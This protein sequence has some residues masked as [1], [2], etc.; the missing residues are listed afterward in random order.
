MSDKDVVS[1]KILEVNEIAFSMK[2]LSED[3]NEL[4]FGKNLQYGLGF[5]LNIEQKS[6]TFRIRTLVN[7][8]IN[9]IN[10]IMVS[11]EVEVVFHVKNLNKVVL[12]DEQTKKL[13]IQNEFLATLIGVCIG[14]SRGVLSTKTK[15]TP[16]ATVPLPIINSKDVVLKMKDS[17][18]I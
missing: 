10:D 13:D 2:P 11:S 14:T 7:Y 5:N 3:I 1:I 8:S 4:E 18:Q 12:L 9:K 6:N 17:H 16:F 15:G